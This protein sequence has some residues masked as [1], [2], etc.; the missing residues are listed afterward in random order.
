[1]TTVGILSDVHMRNDH[2]DAVTETLETIRS[3]LEQENP[4]HVF[5]LGDLIQDSE[6]SATDREHIARVR[7]LLDGL[8]VTYLLGNH[9]T[10]TLPRPEIADILGQTE[11]RGRLDV[12]GESFVYLDSQQ[13]DQRVVGAVGQSQRE[14]LAETMPTDAI[15]LVHHPVGPLPIRDNH[16]FGD[17]PARAF[18]ADQQAVLDTVCPA[19]RA[20]VCGHIHQTSAVRYRGVS[21]LSVN[22][23]SKE[24]PDKPV[25]G[26]WAV[27]DL[28]D[29][30]TADVFVRDEHEKSLTLE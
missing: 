27:L 11:F 8:P 26:T 30:L 23:I 25:T 19:A 21:H 18:L 10:V 12:E 5:V 28:E 6:D 15:V 16:W 24:L 3:R 29:T 7:E 22:A 9:D 14:W 2:R 1:M 4:A 20:T 17:S 13:P